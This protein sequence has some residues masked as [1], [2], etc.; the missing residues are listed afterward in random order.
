VATIIR[1]SGSLRRGS[2]KTA[3]LRAAAQLMPDGTQLQIKTIRAQDRTQPQRVGA[4]CAR[5]RD[6]KRTRDEARDG[7]ALDDEDTVQ[8][9]ALAKRCLTLR[10]RWM[11]S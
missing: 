6:A 8:I 3:L 1:I 11:P 4:A 7:A 10:S 5:C 2:Y 9:T